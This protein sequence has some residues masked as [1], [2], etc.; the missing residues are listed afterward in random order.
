MVAGNAV[1]PR[2]PDS[3]Q[4]ALHPA[5]CPVPRAATHRQVL[6]EAR[7]RPRQA[8]DGQNGDDRERD[9]QDSQPLEQPHVAAGLPLQRCSCVGKG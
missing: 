3:P 1:Q 4:L 7:D 9:A 5:S 8:E 2:V 6:A